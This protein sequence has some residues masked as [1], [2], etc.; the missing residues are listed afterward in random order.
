MRGDLQSVP[1]YL[2]GGGNRNDEWI[3][4]KERQIREHAAT[5]ADR[6]QRGVDPAPTIERIVGDMRG[7][8]HRAYAINGMETGQTYRWTID[9]EKENCSTCLDM[10]GR[11]PQPTA[12]WRE[13]AER[14]IYPGSPSLACGGLH[15]GC[16]Y[17]S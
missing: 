1:F 9:P 16:G 17:E 3:R 15:C 14:G 2:L 10:A 5:I 13:Q 12:F 11:G 6:L 4:D 8:Y 7:V